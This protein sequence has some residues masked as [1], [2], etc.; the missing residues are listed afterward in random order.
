[1]DRTKASSKRG[2]VDLSASIDNASYLVSAPRQ[3]DQADNRVANDLTGDCYADKLPGT[4]A[5]NAKRWGNLTQ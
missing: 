2:G 3:R 4:P 1:M 5:Q